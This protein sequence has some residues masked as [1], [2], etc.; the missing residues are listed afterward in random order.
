MGVLIRL[1]L[2]ILDSEKFVLDEFQSCWQKIKNKSDWRPVRNFWFNSDNKEKTISHAMRHR[3]TTSFPNQ[4]WGVPKKDQAR[5][6]KGQSSSL[7]QKSFFWMFFFYLQRSYT[8]KFSSWSTHNECN[9]LVVH[10]TIW[11][12]IQPCCSYEQHDGKY[13]F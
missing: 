4:Q 12:F 3:T 5:P 1:S 13:V 6:N 10:K 11:S 7:S 2:K 8:H 9:L